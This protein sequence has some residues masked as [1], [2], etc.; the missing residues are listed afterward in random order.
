MRDMENWVASGQIKY[1]EQIVEGLENCVA[2]LKD[3]FEGR[4]FGKSVLK[5]SD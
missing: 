5:V 1:N 4:S 3:V 2:G